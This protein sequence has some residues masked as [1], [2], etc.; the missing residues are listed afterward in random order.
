MPIEVLISYH[1]CV[2]WCVYWLFSK[3]FKGFAPWNLKKSGEQEEQEKRL[4]GEK[5]N[6]CFEQSKKLV[7][8][9][10]MFHNQNIQK[11]QI[12]LKL[13]QN[14]LHLI[15]KDKIQ[16][17]AIYV[18]SDQNVSWRSA[19]LTN[20]LVSLTRNQRLTNFATEK[21]LKPFN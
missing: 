5:L 16:F 2:N 20:T 19:E 7:F 8:L 18:E 10:F 1:C 17:N 13:L 4:I 21:S 12:I 9:E 6:N 15:M 11:L 3:S 14:L